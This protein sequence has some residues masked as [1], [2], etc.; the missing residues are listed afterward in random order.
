MST[1]S[2]LQFLNVDLEVRSSTDL[3][4]LIDDLG[5]DVVNLHTGRVH[6]HY[7]A[8]FEAIIS[9]DADHRISYLCGLVDQLDSEAR[10]SWE[11]ASSKVFD[12]GYEAGVGPKS[13]ES[14]LRPETIAAVARTGA[15]IRVTVYPPSKPPRKAG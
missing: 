5:E 13:Y 10:Q 15:A 2:E 4:P 7:L 11:Q 1:T 6:D 14:N 12:I 8:T 9:G 3:Q